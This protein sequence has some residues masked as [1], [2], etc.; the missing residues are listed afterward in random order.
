LLKCD[1]YSAVFGIVI[2]C[3][4]FFGYCFR[5]DTFQHSFGT[6]ESRGCFHHT[7]NIIIVQILQAEDVNVVAFL[8]VAVLEGVFAVVISTTFILALLP[9][10]PML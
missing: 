4:L 6:L 8:L 1:R 9:I 3:F 7:D 2:E 5:L 10:I